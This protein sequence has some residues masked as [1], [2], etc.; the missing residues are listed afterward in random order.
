MA[1]IEKTKEQLSNELLKERVK[2]KAL[3]EEISNIIDAVSEGILVTNLNGVVTSCNKAFCEVTGFNED[4]IVGKH[5]T[6]LPTLRYSDIPKYIKMFTKPF[7]SEVTKSFEFKWT[8]KDKTTHHGEANVRVVRKKGKIKCYQV[9]LRDITER[10]RVE[11]ALHHERDLIQ[12]IFDNHHDF[13]YFK[14][15][16]TRYHRASKRFCDFLGLSM[17]DIIGKTDLE[18]FPE[19]IAERM[20]NEDLHVIKTGT[21]LINKEE[22]SGGIWVLTTKTPWFDNEGNIIGL[23]GISRDIT[24]RKKAEDALRKSEKW[25]KEAQMLGRI[26]SWEFD[27]EKQTVTWSEETYVLYERDLKLG[28]PSAEE[29]ARY[30]SLEQAKILRDYKTRAIE[31]GR[32]FSFGFRV[33]LPSGKTP[34]YHAVIH[35]VTDIQGR[36]VK[37]FGTITDVTECKKADEELQK[38]ERLESISTLAGGIAHDFNNI[39]TGIMGNISLARRHMEPKG[40]AFERLKEAE[41]ASIR[42]RD[43]T[44]QLLTFSRGGIPVKK[45]VSIAE[46]LEE[47]VTFALRGSNIKAE[48]SL[49][50]DLWATEIDE[51]QISQAFT[52]IVINAD[53]AMP[54][55]GIMRVRAINIAVEAKST[56]QLSR[57]KYVRITFKD[58]GVGISKEH[59]DKIFE[60]YFTT[61]QK[62]SGL[63]LATT[64]SIIKNHDGRIKI[65]SK[66][67]VGSTFYI[68]L[69]A[70][71][72]KVRKNKEQETQPLPFYGGRILVMDDEEAIRELL[73]A[74]LTDAGYEVKA[75][76]DGA[77]AIKKYKEAKEAGALFDLVILDLTI[78]GGIG[79]EEAINKLLEIDPQLKAIVSSGYS[80]DPI[81]GDYE[82]YGFKGVIAKPYSVGEMEK[83]VYKLIREKR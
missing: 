35:P 3:K 77:Q 18:L 7:I 68:Y 25:L 20:H 28:P 57:G 79:G 42:A 2:T 53:E 26:G 43:L 49:P 74:E 32:T 45:P 73:C 39:L 29:E 22:Y 15:R 75:V 5:F 55:G 6:K 33:I 30:Y 82:R 21:S 4:E 13:F 76:K 67:G 71:E 12:N 27:I 41:K 8:H 56:L 60:P 44:M 1:A 70:V 19:E 50:D 40:K 72:K 46:L 16:E 37:L 11:Q 31:T 36:V 65:N 63:G 10:K 17:E 66:L 83:T 78:P 80:N 81:M 51:G 48:F 23:F 38:A 52:N 62:G 58:D 64:Y 34:Y 47:S 9:F 69:P 59:L 61:K 14:D 24:E 54:A